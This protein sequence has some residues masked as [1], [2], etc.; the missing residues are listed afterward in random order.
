MN[1][2][3]FDI[4]AANG[5]KPY[6]ICSIGIVEADENFNVINRQNIWINPK[7]KYNLNGTRKNVGIDLHLDKNLLDNSP[8]FSQVYDKIRTLLLRKDIVV[9]GHAVDS[10]VRMLNAACNKYKLPCLQFDFVC[11]QLLYKLYKGDKDVKALNKIANE[12][13][14]VYNEHNSE[15]DAW[16]SLMTLKYIINDSGLSFEQLLKK[17]VIRIGTNNNF[18]ITR[19]VSLAGQEGVAKKITQK[20][21]QELKKYANSIKATGD[22]LSGKVVAVARSLELADEQYARKIVATIATQGGKYTTKL[23]NCNM[24][25][26]PT[27]NTPQDQMR[28]KRVHELEQTGLLTSYT[29]QQFF[30]LTGVEQ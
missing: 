8:D 4:E 12:L 1:Y 24:Y 28:Q 15:D 25:I 2:L 10:D 13:N 23:R 14:L 7:T 6:S 22:K 30:Q 20:S 26:L 21:L 9:L 3:A 27:D 11:S 18:E 19:C 17:Y 29:L 16:M 5:Y